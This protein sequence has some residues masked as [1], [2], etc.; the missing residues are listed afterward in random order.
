M[1]QTSPWTAATPHGTEENSTMSEGSHSITFSCNDTD[2][3]MNS[4]ATTQYFK[5]DTF[6][7]V[8]LESPTANYNTSQAHN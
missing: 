5:V 4:T 6:P 7:T 2:G 3:N 8:T 1:P